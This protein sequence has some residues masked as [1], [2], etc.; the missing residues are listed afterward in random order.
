[1]SVDPDV[2]LGRLIRRTR[3]EAGLSCLALAQA[4]DIEPVHLA[5][6]EVGSGLLLFSDAV[7]LLHACGTTLGASGRASRPISSERS[8]TSTRRPTPRRFSMHEPARSPR[9]VARRRCPCCA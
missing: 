3:G 2:V 6:L 1:M 5:R 9:P 8:R 7:P 4:L